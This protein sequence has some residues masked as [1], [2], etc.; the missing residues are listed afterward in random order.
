MYHGPFRQ[1]LECQSIFPHL[2]LRPCINVRLVVLQMG[3]RPSWALMYAQY[4]NDK[5][6]AL[7]EKPR[8]VNT[9]FLE[10]GQQALIDHIPHTPISRSL[11]PFFI[12]TDEQLH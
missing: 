8:M 2:S 11:K 4:I 9:S 7:I 5:C 6:L 1:N 12:H 3:R 10:P